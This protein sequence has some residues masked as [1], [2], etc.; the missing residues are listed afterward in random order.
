MAKFTEQELVEMLKPITS[1]GEEA[2][3]VIVPSVWQVPEGY[4]LE[5]FQV[6][7]TQVEH[8]IPKVKK[9]S[10][11]IYQ[12]HGGGYVFRYMDLYRDVALKYSQAAGG[13]EVFSIDY[14]CVPNHYYPSALEEAKNVYEWILKQGYKAENIVFAGDSAGGNLELVL[15][16][17]LRD[18]GMKLPKAIIAV[19]PWTSQGNEFPSI[20]TNKEKDLL[21]GVQSPALHKVVLDSP[22]AKDADLKD[23]YVSPLYGDFHKF[24][25]MLVQCGSHEMFLDEVTAM[26]EKAKEAGTKVTFHVYPKMFHDFQLVIPILD[27]AVKAWEDIKKFLAKLNRK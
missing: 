1:I 23:P 15:T 14:G 5:K 21:L 2:M 17:Y 6:N 18:H 24:P 16:M 25:P 12:L 22:Y 19:S 26:A 13:A 11:V 20:E 8:L 4:I 10:Q 27:E 9:S 7:G 3:D